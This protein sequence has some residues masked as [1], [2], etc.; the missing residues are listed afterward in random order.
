[1]PINSMK[2]I[3]CVPLQVKQHP[4]IHISTVGQT[5]GFMS[6]KGQKE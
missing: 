1:M 6:V 5:I 3:E 4:L 2:T